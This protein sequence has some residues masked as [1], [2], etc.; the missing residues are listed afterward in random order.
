[1]INTINNIIIWSGDESTHNNCIATDN[2]TITEADKD[3]I[4]RLQNDLEE[5]KSQGMELQENLQRLTATNKNLDD[6]NTD[7]KAMVQQLHEECEQ[8]KSV[9]EDKEMVIQTMKR[10]EGVK[11]TVGGGMGD[12]SLTQDANFT[13]DLTLGT[14]IWFWPCLFRIFFSFRIIN[15]LSLPN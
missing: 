1:M 13:M 12:K 4:R 7:L 11:G 14:W 2:P 9:I 5:Y 8:L 15:S 10:S 3:L 6:S